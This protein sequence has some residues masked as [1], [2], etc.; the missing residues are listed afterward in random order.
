MRNENNIDIDERLSQIIGRNNTD[1]SYENRYSVAQ[2]MINEINSFISSDIKQTEEGNI[3]RQDGVVKL[4]KIFTKEQVATLKEYFISKTTYRSH[5]PPGDGTKRLIHNA[6]SRF[7][8]YDPL[9]VINAPYVLDTALSDRILT[10]TQDY[11]GCIP[12]L[13]SFNTFWVLSRFTP[14]ILS[15][16]QKYHRDLDDFKFLTFFIYLTDVDETSSP[17]IFC[18]GSHLNKND[19]A[20]TSKALMLTGEAGEGFLADTYGLHMG[21]PRVEKDRLVVWLRYGLHY[22]PPTQAQ[23]PSP[24]PK[25]QIVTPISNDFKTRFITRLFIRD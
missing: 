5:V 3:L 15:D 2:S 22:N 13:Y 12:T 19:N 21:S 7:N 14:E 8:C 9:D 16:I 11:L 17:H 25:S 23:M 6:I 20:D 1:S 10:I 24:Y 4:G 18:R